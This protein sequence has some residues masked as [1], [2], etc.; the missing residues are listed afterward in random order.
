MLHITYGDW[1]QES[2]EITLLYL[3]TEVDPNLQRL[4]AES[5]YTYKSS[6]QIT[7]TQSDTSR[8]RRRVR[9]QGVR[10]GVPKGNIII[11]SMDLHYILTSLT[12]NQ[13][14]N[15]CNPFAFSRWPKPPASWHRVLL[16]IQIIFKDYWGIIGYFTIKAT[17]SQ[18]G[19]S[20]V[21]VQSWNRRR[22]L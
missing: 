22:V 7:E 1:V 15:N 17:G 3:L 18:A 13:R 8:S 11:L 21:R 6:P 20:M 12:K 16:C 4:D 19:R 9:R 5:P 14:N 10:W 2:N